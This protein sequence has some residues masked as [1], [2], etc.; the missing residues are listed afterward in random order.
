MTW[1]DVAAGDPFGPQTLPY[2]VLELGDGPQCAV[3]IGSYAL[4]LRTAAAELVPELSPVL[5]AANLDALLAAGPVAWSG[6]RAAVRAWL[7]DDRHR[8]TVEPLLVPL[9]AHRALLPWSV[10]DYVDFY[11]SEQHATNVGRIFRPDGAAL[12]VNWKYLPVGYHG[13]A[14]TVVASGAEIR[15]PSG[16]RRSAS[17]VTFGPS[18]RLDFEAEVGFVVGASSPMGRPLAV[19]EFADH[20]FGAVLLNDWSARDIQSWEYVPLGPFLGKSFATSVSAWITPLAA[21]NAARLPTVPQE[22][23]PAGY[24]D[25]GG[26]SWALDLQLEVSINGQLVCSPP[27]REMYWTP[28]QMLAHLTVNGASTRPG[29][30][31][32]SGTVSGSRRDQWGSMLELSWNGAEP[33]IVGGGER[34]FLLDGDEVVMTATAPGPDGC[35]VGIAEVRGRVAA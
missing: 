28:A 6:A 5:G 22:P 35:R 11:A 2:G 30:L 27:F 29:D 24:L 14:G 9:G 1:V 16:Q 32:G 21:L 10:A 8:P 13:R 18:E 15:R 4:P 19:A 26:A 23:E 31:I 34:A 20:V 17:E 25:D 7:T 3:R 33:L 12:P